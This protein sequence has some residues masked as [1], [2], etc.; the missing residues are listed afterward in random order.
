MRLRFVVCRFFI[1]VSPFFLSTQSSFFSLRFHGAQSLSFLFAT[2]FGFRIFHAL[3]NP[4]K[5]A[6]QSCQTAKLLNL[7][8]NPPRKD[9][10]FVTAQLVKTFLNSQ[11][12]RA[13]RFAQTIVKPP[14]KKPRKKRRAQKFEN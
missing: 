9:N 6:A 7:V 5:W 13:R 11:K 14:R 1:C 2:F 10:H 8:F 12:N 3:V 4:E